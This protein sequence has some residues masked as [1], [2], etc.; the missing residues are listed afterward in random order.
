LRAGGCAL[1]ADAIRRILDD[2]ERTPVSLLRA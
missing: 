2:L 1:L